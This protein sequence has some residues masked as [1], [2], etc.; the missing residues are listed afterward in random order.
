[1]RHFGHGV[2]TSSLILTYGSRQVRFID[3]VHIKEGE[4]V[5]VRF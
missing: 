3:T 4:T 5:T 1:V 2:R